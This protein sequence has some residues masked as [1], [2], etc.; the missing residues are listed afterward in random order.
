MLFKSP[1]NL[2]AVLLKSL[3]NL[4]DIGIQIVDY[5]FS[6]W[7]LMIKQCTRSDE[8]FNIGHVLVSLRKLG[9]EP[10]FQEVFS[11]HS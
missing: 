9:D 7:I 6:T 8:R 3:M 11:T 1:V 2:F 4:I 5:F 10:F